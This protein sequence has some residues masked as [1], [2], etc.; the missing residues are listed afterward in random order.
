LF[1]ICTGVNKSAVVG[2]NKGAVVRACVYVFF[3]LY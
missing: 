1:L 2:V 3:E